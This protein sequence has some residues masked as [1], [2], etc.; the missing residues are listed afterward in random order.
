MTNIAIYGAADIYGDVIQ[1][2]HRRAGRKGRV[3]APLGKAPPGHPIG[4]IAPGRPGADADRADRI[5]REGIYGDANAGN[6][7]ASISCS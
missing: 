4:I 6:D 7:R 3:P 2:E 5:V 1:D